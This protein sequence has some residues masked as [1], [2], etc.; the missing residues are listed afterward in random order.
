M[1]NPTE[2]LIKQLDSIKQINAE[3]LRLYNEIIAQRDMLYKSIKQF[4]TATEQKSASANNVLLF[5]SSMGKAYCG[6]RN[7]LKNV[8]DNKHE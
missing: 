4:I 3:Q 6:L 7:A 8:E 1:S 2:E 5:T